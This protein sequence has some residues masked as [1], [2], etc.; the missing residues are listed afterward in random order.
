M[1]SILIHYS[2]DSHLLFNVTFWMLSLAH[3]R[4]KLATITNYC[5]S[6][7]DFSGPGIKGFWLQFIL[8]DSL[9]NFLKLMS[10]PA[11]QHPDGSQ[12]DLSADPVFPHAQPLRVRQELCLSHRRGLW[13]LHVPLW[14]HQTDNHQVSLLSSFSLSFHPHLTWWD[15]GLLNHEVYFRIWSLWF[16]VCQFN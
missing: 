1:H 16:I 15:V 11:V 7:L 9:S 2:H 12:W 5:T 8:L 3:P 4:I 10:S 6:Q 14:P 13:A